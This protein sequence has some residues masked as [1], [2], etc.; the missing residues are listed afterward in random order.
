MADDDVQYEFKSV[1]AIRGTEARTIAKW[2]KSGWELD[3][4][5]PGA[6]RT[7]LSF[8]RVKKKMP[9]AVLVAVIAFALVV[10]GVIIAGIVSERDDGSKPTAASSNMPA[11]SAT[12]SKKPSESPIPTP[13]ATASS[14]APSQPVPAGPLTKENNADVAAL[15]SVDDYCADGIRDFAEKYEGQSVQ[16]D[17]VIT[18]MASHADYSTR[19]DILISAG[20]KVNAVVGPVFKFESVNTTSDLHWTG[21]NVPD[22]V[23][24]GSKLRFT[25]Q[26]DHYSASQ[27]IFF[28]DPAST[29]GR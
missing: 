17:G 6:L 23:G 25:A 3:S 10:V 19:Y 24:K 16:F 11:P 18:D 7:D 28:L 20:D 5:T 1:K 21:S 13:S 15:L 22:S 2:E 9:K 4:R 12:P 29:E 14:A 26:V 8:R 27:C